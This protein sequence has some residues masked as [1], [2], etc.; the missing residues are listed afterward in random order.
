MPLRSAPYSFPALPDLSFHGL[1]GK[2]LADSLPDKYGNALIDAW[3]AT[4]GRRPEDFNA[5]ERLSY[6]GSRGMGAL[7]FRPVTG[8]TAANATPVNI[9]ALVELASQVLTHRETLNVTFAG[10]DKEAALREI[11]RVGTSAGD[12]ARRRRQ[13]IAWN[14]NAHQ[15]RSDPAS[16]AAPPSSSTAQLIKFDGVQGNKDKDLADPQGYGSRRVC[17]F[18][19]GR[20]QPESR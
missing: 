11:L 13:V 1:P 14:V 2:L 20:R 7:E 15:R 9:D 18:L 3:L 5:V 10:D 19:H 12:A 6:T 16:M 4:Q 17:L 8:P